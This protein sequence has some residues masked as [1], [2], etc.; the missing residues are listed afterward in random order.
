MIEA[1][2]FDMDGLLVDS[3]PLWRQAEQVV[4]PRVGIHLTDEMCLQ[5]MGTR[6]D[7]VV[8]HWFKTKPWEGPSLK[9]VADEIVEAVIDLVRREGKLKE[10]GEY[11]LDFCASQGL[12]IA[13]ASSSSARLIEAVVDQF[14]IRK[15]FSVLQSAESEPYGKPHPGVFL[16]TAAKLG[17][18]PTACLVFEDSFAGVI[19]AKAARMKVV[20]VPAAE[21]YEQNCFA[22]ADLKL[23][24]LRQ[25]DAAALERLNRDSRAKPRE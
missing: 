5:T 14:G 1:A 16:T 20:A 15:Y 17:I 9:E 11:I 10:G 7:E 21:H 24:S 12:E 3:E 13:L 8:Q 19:A 2:I 6:V 4:F 25:F 18:E 22:I 23:R